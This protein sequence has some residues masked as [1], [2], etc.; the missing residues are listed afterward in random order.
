MILEALH[1]TINTIVTAYPL[2]GDIEAVVPFAVYAVDQLPLYM[3]SGI[4]GYENNVS[5]N[6]VDTDLQQCQA[7]SELVVAALLALSGS[8]NSTTFDFSRLIQS[9]ARFDEKSQAYINFIQIK[10]FTQNI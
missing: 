6:V 2:M 8:V 4:T 10:M 1:T 7:K 9:T 5:I 3:K